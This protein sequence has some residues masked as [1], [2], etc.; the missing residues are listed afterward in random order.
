LP[1]HGDCDRDGDGDGDADIDGNDVYDDGDKFTAPYSA[2]PRGV[3]SVFPVIVVLKF[4]MI[5]A[6]LGGVGGK[7]QEFENLPKVFKK[8][9][10]AVRIT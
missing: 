3:G 9:L 7:E 6:K 8:F 2:P 10:T 4:C 1:P 5:A